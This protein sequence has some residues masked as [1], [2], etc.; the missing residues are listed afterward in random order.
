MFRPLRLGPLQDVP[1][2]QLV[3]SIVQPL[4]AAARRG[5][6]VAPIAL[7]I[8][9]SFG[10]DGFWYGV[11]LALRP[12]Q[13]SRM[14]LYCTWPEELTA[15]YDE[16]GFIEID[17]RVEDILT[18]VVPLVWDQ[19]RY[20]GRS[21]AVDEFLDVLQRYGVASG[22]MCALRDHR[23]ALAAL[24]LSS[25]LPIVDEVRRVT[26]ARHMGDILMFQRY[27]HELFV[28]G[29]LK[30]LVPPYL[31]GVKL[32]PRELECLAMAARGLTGEDIAIKLGISPRTV[33]NHFDSI[34]SK[35]GAANRQE[36]IFRA[37]QMGLLAA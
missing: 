37:T 1:D 3:P 12:R 28:A 8:V 24:S 6:D 4:L 17:P 18:S 9:K 26:I 35:L 30:E 27:F 25:G 29:V 2:S 36:A 5:D 34:R 15:I 21:R 11:S 16:R 13:E 7:S 22:V 10:F 32:S 14:F 19:P 31:E 23:S 20:R 33:Q